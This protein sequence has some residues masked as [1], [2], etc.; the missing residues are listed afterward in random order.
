MLRS[1]TL[2]IAL[3][4]ISTNLAHAQRQARPSAFKHHTIDAA[5]QAAQ[6]SQLPLLLFVHSDNCRFCVKMEKETYS[7]P[8]IAAAVNASSESVSL[9]KE[10]NL[11]LVK[12]LQVRAYPTT[13]VVSPSGKEIGRIEG[14][15]NPQKF[16]AK[17]FAP[18]APRQAVQPASHRGSAAQR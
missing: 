10:Q 14:F 5:W 13:I 6:K 9:R 8:K 12:R 15:L 18:S 17:M 7:H 1:A 11:E 16:A 3:L 2:A 4:A